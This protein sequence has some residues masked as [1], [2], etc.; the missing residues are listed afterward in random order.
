MASL[1]ISYELDKW[2]LFVDW[3]KVSLKA[4]L[5]YNGSVLPAI[6]LAHA[7][8][9]KETYE[10]LKRLL[11]FFHYRDHNWQICGDLKIIA[12]LVGLQ[13]GYIKY[14]CFPREWDCRARDLHYVKKMA[15]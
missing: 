2:R 1:D 12:L 10:N 11:N 7:F 15:S 6:P 8:H 9:I 13:T 14:F 4:V 3:S 5:L